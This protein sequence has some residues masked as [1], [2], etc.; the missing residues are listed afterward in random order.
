M[1]V[2]GSAGLLDCTHHG[3][4]SY[5]SGVDGDIRSE[6]SFVFSGF[7]RALRALP[8]EPNFSLN[9]FQKA[10]EMQMSNFISNLGVLI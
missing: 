6:K 5:T 2:A 4:D 3:T 9:L 10:L 8:T 7:D 1:I